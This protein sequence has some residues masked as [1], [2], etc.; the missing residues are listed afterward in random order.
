M[1]YRV[2]GSN[3]INNIIKTTLNNRGINNWKEYLNLNSVDDDE[4]ANLDNINEAIECFTSH[5]ERGSNVGILFDTD[6]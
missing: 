1:Q 6:T 5:I 4:F 3:D 2:I